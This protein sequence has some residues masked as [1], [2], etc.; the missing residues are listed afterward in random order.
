MKFASH[1]LAREIPLL[2]HDDRQFPMDPERRAIARRIYSGIRDLPIIS[3]HGHTNPVWFS[4]NKSFPNPTELLITPDHYVFRM[5]MSQGIPLEEMGIST[6]KASSS[7]DPKQV[8]RIF[9]SHYYLFRGTPSRIWLDWIFFNVFGLK[10]LLNAGNADFY[11]ETIDQ[12]LRCDDFRPRA[13][14]E[15]F[16]IEVLT[17]TEGPLDRLETHDV[18]RRSGWGGRILTAYRPDNVTDPESDGFADNLRAF[19]IVADEDLST[20]DSYRR[21]HC[22][23]R[24][25]FKQHGATSTDHGHPDAF[26]ADLSLDDTRS[27]YLKI[28]NGNFAPSDA[29]LFRGQMLTEMAGMSVEDGLVMQLHPG[30]S[31]NHNLEVYQ[32]F[33]T[34]M[35]GDIPVAGEYVNNLKPLLNRWGNDPRLT[36]IVFTVDET[37]FSRELAPLAG[38]YPA[39][40]LGPPWWYLDSPA[41]MLRFRAAVTETAGFY[42]T[43][44]FNDDTRAFLSIPARHDVA[45]RADSTYLATLVGEHMLHEAEAHEVAHQLTYELVKSAYKL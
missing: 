11:Y 21:A 43:V 38:H 44:G 22:K 18:I 4:E 1:D 3:P 5:L 6:H 34:D 32:K 17:T 24:L 2:M 16:N 28:L 27:L 9:A 33:G 39:L 20:F 30:V 19:G 15:R 42:N 10:V 37:T 25:F 41:G 31:R 26:T 45:R 23:R 40:R 29:R 36:F 13:L 8:W 12:K 7:A 14:Y 35:G